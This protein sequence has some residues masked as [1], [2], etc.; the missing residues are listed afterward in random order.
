M[1]LNMGIVGDRYQLAACDGLC[2]R[3][4]AGAR[5][6]LGAQA[7]MRAAVVIADVLVQDALGLALAEDQHVVETVATERPHQA[8]ANRVRQRRSGRRG[9]TSH[10]EAAEPGTE[11]ARRR[12]CRGRAADSA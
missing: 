3:A 5:G 8:F 6:R 4:P 7:A 11:K 1:P 12:C 10:P 2:W 9:K